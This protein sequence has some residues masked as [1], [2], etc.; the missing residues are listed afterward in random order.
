MDCG[1]AEVYASS[2]RPFALLALAAFGCGAPPA[3][4]T[5]ATR[6][7]P[8][9][10]TDLVSPLT[11]AGVD[12]PQALDWGAKGDEPARQI[13]KNVNVLGDLTGNRM[14]AGMQS[15]DG[16]LGVGCDHCHDTE[17]YPSDAKT[18]KDTARKMLRM[19]HDI[20]TR[21]FEGRTF[22]TCFTCHRRESEP[23]AFTPTKPAPEWPMPP[24]SADEAAK[25]AKTIFKNLEL[26]GDVPAGRIPTV[27]NLFATALGVGCAHCHD[28]GDWASDKKP[29]KKRARDMLRMVRA[30]GETYFSADK[31]PVRCGTCH[32]GDVRPARTAGPLVVVAATLASGEPSPRATFALGP[33]EF[34]PANRGKLREAIAADEKEN[35]LFATSTY[36]AIEGELGHV[37]PGTYSLCAVSLP[38]DRKNDPRGPD[39]PLACA[40][41]TVAAEPE[42]QTFKRELP[43]L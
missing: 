5:P 14:M 19:A 18:P 33:P 20:D 27:M 7:L 40:P 17:N 42:T 4:T 41:L 3:T 34:A 23:E 16:S 2:M 6:P 37:P 9:A 1:A 8:P 32:R 31:N 13:F 29:A 11:A 24:L 12:H 39:R 22:V 15:M 10:T 38:E 21:F 28:T 35:K 25:P 30:I 36:H 43:P 26:T